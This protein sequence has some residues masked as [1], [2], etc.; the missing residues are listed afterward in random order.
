M[1]S[2]GT[3]PTLKDVGISSVPLFSLFYLFSLLIF[4]NY[5]I[6]C[7]KSLFSFDLPN[8]QDLYFLQQN[9]RN[10]YN[11][12]P[13][14]IDADDLQDDPTSILGQLCSKLGIPFS[15]KMVYPY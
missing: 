8:L 12:D 11:Q 1:N 10:K 14:V 4:I 5:E 7:V 3:A 2:N 13:I 9:L 15:S 6:Y